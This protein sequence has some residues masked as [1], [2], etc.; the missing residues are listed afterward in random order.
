MRQILLTCL[1]FAT[2]LSFAVPEKNVLKTVDSIVET[3]GKLV[4]TYTLPCTTDDFSEIVFMYDDSGDMAI[5]AGVVYSE[6]RRN[7]NSDGSSNTF[8]KTI[9]DYPKAMSFESLNVKN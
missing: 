9:K 8:T 3:N 5:G 6:E 1:T 4:I 7:C 2:T